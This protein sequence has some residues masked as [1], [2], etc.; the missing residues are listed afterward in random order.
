VVTAASG[1]VPDRG[2]AIWISFS[3]Q[4][5]TEQAGHRPALVLSPLVF[6]ARTGLA[7]LCPIRSR[8]KRHGFEIRVPK[9]LPITGVILADQIKSL[10]W[11]ARRADYIAEFPT[12][13]VDEVCRRIAS[14]LRIEL[15]DE[16]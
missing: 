1:Y 8:A 10:D 7:V 2:H 15:L 9:G 14:I 6:N 3:P 12:E 4:I 11:R 13:T 5:G 16:R